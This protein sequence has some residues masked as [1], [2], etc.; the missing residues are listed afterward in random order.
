M[1]TGPQVTFPIIGIIKGKPKFLGTGFFIDYLGGFVTAKHVLDINDIDPGTNYVI[2]QIIDD[3]HFQPRKV[4][5][6][7][8]HPTADICLG[9]PHLMM[10]DD[11]DFINPIWELEF[12][13]PSIKEVVKT[14]AYPKSI[15]INDQE[16]IWRFISDEFRGE[17]LEVNDRCPTCG[18]TTECYQTNIEMLSGSSGGPVFNSSG[19][20]IGINS[21][22]FELSGE[23]PPISFV[24]PLSYLLEIPIFS[25][26]EK[27]TFG[28]LRDRQAKES[29]IYDQ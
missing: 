18:L 12:S 25:E 5:H 10:V 14:L 6:I 1:N 16:N 3:K 11:K 19:K 2:L 27:L 29:R 28:E 7:F 13:R 20:V 9:K 23:D 26:G 8:Y 4:E 15:V 24:T 21:I 17:I 22:S